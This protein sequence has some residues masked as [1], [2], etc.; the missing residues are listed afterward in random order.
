M[1]YCTFFK[2]S[3]VEYETFEYEKNLNINSE[4]KFLLETYLEMSCTN[5]WHLYAID[6]QNTNLAV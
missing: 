3:V 6:P 4:S 1:T 5:R 2:R